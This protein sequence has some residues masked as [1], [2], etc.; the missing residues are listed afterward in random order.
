MKGTLRQRGPSSWEIQVFLGRDSNGKRIRKTETVRGKKSVAERRLREILTDMDKGITPTKTR[1]KLGEWLDKW[2]EEKITPNCKSKTVD[3]YEGIIRLHIK[4]TL[5]HIELSKLSPLDVQNLETRLLLGGPKEPMEPKGVE[6]VHNVMSGAMK[7]ALRLEQITRNPVALVSPP[8]VPKTEAY[9]P[10]LSQVRNLLS[11]AESNGHPLWACIYLIAYTGMRRGEALAL[12]W[13]H[14]DFDKMRISIAQS[15]VV[16]AGGVL[17]E[18]PKTENGIR[19][20]DLDQQT[21]EVLKTHRDN[22]RILATELGI[23]PPEKLFPRHDL[24]GWTHPNTIWYAVRSLSKQAG[25]PGVTS[26]SL[27]HFHAS[28]LLQAGQNPAVVAQRIGHSSPKITMEVYAHALPGW[29]EDAAEAFAEAM[30]PAA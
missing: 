30:K 18:T 27:R 7:Y 15:L 12:T 28:M 24:S 5:G 10:E 8:T 1:Y 17:E 25:C 9:S 26:R 14:V 13:K 16:A 20:V 21:A 2:L 19:T 6:A 23:N 29:Q 3:R 22:Q 11:L 4:P